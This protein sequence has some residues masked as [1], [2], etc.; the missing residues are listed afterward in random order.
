MSQQQ[1]QQIVFVTG[2]TKGGI[3]A[4]VCKEYAEHGARV[5]AGVR[6]IEA[7]GAELEQHANVQP[8]IVDVADEESVA[9]AV[10]EVV[11]QSGGRIDVLVNNAGTNTSTGAAVEVPLEQYEKTFAVN[12]FGLIRVTQHV[13][14]YMLKQRSGTVVNIG[15][16]AGYAH[17]PWSAA[18]SSSKA[19]VHSFSDVLRVELAPFGVHV[20]CVA[21]GKIKSGFGDSALSNVTRPSSESPFRRATKLIEARAQFSQVGSVTPAADMARAIRR[22]VEQPSWRRH[23]YLT[24]GVNSTRAWML[25]FLPP[26]LRD[27]ALTRMFKLKTIAGQ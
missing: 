1:K 15:S 21:P 26:F 2:C 27:A 24:Y 11:R 18:Y 16:T 19:A 3:G 4:A 8:V 12:Y 25:Y 5:F 14:P 7:L 20:L 10:E 9:R 23:A 17:L 6:K 22:S 13:V